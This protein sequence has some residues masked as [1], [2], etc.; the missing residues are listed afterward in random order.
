[1]SRKPEPELGGGGEEIVVRIACRAPYG[2]AGVDPPT[3]RSCAPLVSSITDSSTRPMSVRI[4]RPFVMVAL[5]CTLTV[6]AQLI[7]SEVSSAR[8]PIS[9]TLDAPVA[10]HDPQRLA[11]P[12]P[13]DRVPARRHLLAADDGVRRDRRAVARGQV[14]QGFRRRLLAGGAQL[15]VA[16]PVGLGDL[17]S[18]LCRQS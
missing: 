4:T 10:I 8:Q 13:H 15:L 11:A 16:L 17:L 18:G 5:H 1:M 7:R 9:E 3:S 2:A 14:G 6:S 12:Q